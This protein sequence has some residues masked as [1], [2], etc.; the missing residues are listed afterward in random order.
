MA[1]ILEEQRKLTG[2]LTKIEAELKLIRVEVSELKEKV[3]K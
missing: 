1:H 2:G 3:K